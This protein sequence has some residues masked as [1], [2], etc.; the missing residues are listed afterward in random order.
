[1]KMIKKSLLVGCGFISV[2]LGMLGAILPILPTVPFLLLAS[3]C[4]VKGSERCDA[5]FKNTGLYKKQLKSFV[6]NKCMTRNQKAVILLTANAMLC[7]PFFMVDNLYMRIFIIA[8]VIWKLW[9]FLFQIGT[10]NEQKTKAAQNE[11][12]KDSIVEGS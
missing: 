11:R 5:W 3:V 6:Q 1:M 7:F 10:V 4:F 12:K 9:Y 8:L 2:A